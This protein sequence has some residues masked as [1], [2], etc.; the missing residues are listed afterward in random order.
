LAGGEESDDPDGDLGAA[1]KQSVERGLLGPVGWEKATIQQRMEELKVPAVAV[2][3]VD[4]CQLDWADGFGADVTARTLFQAASISKTITALAALRM[5]AAGK[6]DL[7]APAG[8]PGVTLA[9]LLNHTAGFNVPGFPGY[10]LD[11]PVPTMDQVLSGHSPSA[12]PQ[13]AI[14]GEPGKSYAYSGGGT[15]LVQKI[16]ERAAGRTFTELTREYVLGPLGM[17]SSMFA[18]PLPPEYVPRA[19]K[20]H[21]YMGRELPGGFRIYPELAAAGLWTTAADLARLVIAVNKLQLDPAEGEGGVEGR[22]APFGAS[23][24]PSGSGEPFLSKELGRRMVKDSVPGECMKSGLG[25][26]TMEAGGES[27]LLHWGANA[28]YRSLF[29]CRPSRGQGVAV[30]T[31][32]DNGEELIAEVV[33]SVAA[34]QRWPG[35]EPAS[36]T[37]RKLSK[38]ALANLCGKYAD[39]FATVE[40]TAGDGVAL[41][42]TRPD[43]SPLPMYTENGV[44]FWF[45]QE[46]GAAR[47]IFD[48]EELVLSNCP[49]RAERFKRIR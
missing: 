21:D 24:A 37:P 48:G 34:L 12:T 9:R 15:L 46:L 29:I 32:G 20:G 47:V 3:V 26:F 49:S 13:V 45:A 8:L 36:F 14:M 22:T 6:L 41:V 19:A 40:V 25:I 23:G 44:E 2:A 27:Y 33:R 42:K 18:Q 35:F 10:A 7:D 16:M 38:G 17:A 31:A 43:V 4:G 11:A 5:A 28:G 39:K 30:L 1:R